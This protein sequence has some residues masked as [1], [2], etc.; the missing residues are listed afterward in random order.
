M[1]HAKH[2]QVRQRYEFRCG[3]C[4][5]SEVDTG[6]ELTVDHYHPVAA[7]G[8]DTDDNLVYA[9]FKCNQ[10]KGDYHPTE[11]DL[12]RQLRVL[13]PWATTWR[14]IPALTNTPDEWNR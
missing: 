6:G 2:A 10:Y 7:G 11:E 5:V 13:H 9:C 4:G 3:Y 1:A 8:D 12:A 14:H